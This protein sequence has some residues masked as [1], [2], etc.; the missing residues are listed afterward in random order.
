MQAK[1]VANTQLCEKLSSLLGNTY[2][3]KQNR[4]EQ[5][6]PVCYIYLKR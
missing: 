2:Y 5:K 1:G 6:C 4:L 3:Q